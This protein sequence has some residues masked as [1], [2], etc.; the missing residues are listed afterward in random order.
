MDSW[1]PA[2]ADYSACG[3][4]VTNRFNPGNR[5]S[6]FMGIALIL[7]ACS[8]S[9]GPSTGPE[10]IELAVRVHLVRSD[11]LE[12]LNVRLSDAEVD[13]LM[14]AVNETWAQA[15]IIWGVESIV[16]DDAR[17]ESLFSHALMDPTVSLVS[18]LT[19]VLTP[20]NLGADIWNVFMIRDFGGE[21]GGV[22]LPIER[23]VVS[24]EIDPGGQR[25]TT[26]GMAR[27]LAHE[28]GHSLG[29]DHVPCTAQGNLMAAGC[30]SGSR[31][32]LHATQIAGVRRQA[33]TG[34]PF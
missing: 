9:T 28:L 4:R 30:M 18:V 33:K 34:R 25:D 31:T 22:Y 3:E 21:L 27:I 5:L 15:G 20:E 14:T 8:D 13:E 17:N 6:G 1:E 16:R 11:Q 19:S 2:G 24:A 29:L 32:F 7:G 26:G 23:V 12:A 10:P